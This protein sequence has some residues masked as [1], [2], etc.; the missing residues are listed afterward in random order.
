MKKTYFKP[1]I[2]VI[3][4]DL[5]EIL[6]TNLPGDFSIGIGEDDEEGI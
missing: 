1:E 2:E 4:F 6:M 3:D 5:Q